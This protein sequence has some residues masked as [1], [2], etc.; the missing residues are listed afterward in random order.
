MHHFQYITLYLRNSRSITGIAFVL[1]DSSICKI[2]ILCISTK[3]CDCKASQPRCDCSMQ[4]ENE[5]KRPPEKKNKKEKNFRIASII[6]NL[7]KILM[8][9]K[10]T[11][12][13][14]LEFLNLGIVG[15]E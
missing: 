13:K 5:Q 3:P 14:Q 7:L 15:V 12:Q 10:V 8:N 6:S 2:S 11:V 1:T 4:G 9:R